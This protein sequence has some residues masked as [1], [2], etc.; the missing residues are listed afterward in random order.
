MKKKFS[1]LILY[2]E[3]HINPLASTICTLC[4]CHI[5][6]YEFSSILADIEDDEESVII[7]HLSDLFEWPEP[8]STQFRSDLMKIL[9][10]IY[11]E[12][13]NTE[14]SS[15]I[16]KNTTNIIDDDT[17]MREE[18]INS[19]YIS[20]SNAI[21]NIEQKT[22]AIENDE[23]QLNDETLKLLQMLS[24]TYNSDIVQSLQRFCIEHEVKCFYFY[25]V[26]IIFLYTFTII[27]V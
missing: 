12:N 5:L 3:L 25:S 10:N 27:K 4:F 21:A 20:T 15:T 8:Q 11:V 22:N 13:V 19:I 26:T 16:D 7:E 18:T 6:K 17:K 2:F 9:K 14:I 1:F 24:Q 23:Y